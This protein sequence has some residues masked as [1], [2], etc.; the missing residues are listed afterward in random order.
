M[1]VCRYGAIHVVD[2]GEREVID[3]ELAA[4]VVQLEGMRIEDGFVDGVFAWV[5]AADLVPLLRC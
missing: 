4:E 1:K 3:G 5:P 2:L